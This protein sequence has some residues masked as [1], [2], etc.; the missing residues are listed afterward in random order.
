MEREMAMVH[1]RS[2]TLIAVILA[3]LAFV[4]A[5]VG[6]GFIETILVLAIAASAAILLAMLVVAARREAY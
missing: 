4:A 5:G 3:L 2:K 6:I 1:G